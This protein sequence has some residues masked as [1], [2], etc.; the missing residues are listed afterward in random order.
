MWLGPSLTGLG[1]CDPAVGEFDFAADGTYLYKNTSDKCPG[2]ANSGPYMVQ[3][4][5]LQLTIEQCDP[6]AGCVPGSQLNNAI[7]FIDANTIV[8]NNQFTYHRQ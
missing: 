5:V 8:L 1:E 2:F 4:N 3:G 7:N 6:T